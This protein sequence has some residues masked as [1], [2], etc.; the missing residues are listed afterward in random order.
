MVEL[1]S[2]KKATYVLASI[3]LCAA[4]YAGPFF[5]LRRSSALALRR[6][7]A[8]AFTFA[9]YPL[10]LLTADRQPFNKPGALAGNL[11]ATFLSMI[12]TDS[13]NHYL[14]FS[15]T[16][17]DICSTGCNDDVAARVHDMEPGTKMRLA[18]EGQLRWVATGPGGFIMRDRIDVNIVSTETIVNP[19]DY[20]ASDES[21]TPPK[22]S[23]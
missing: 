1:A 3:L 20:P 15:T 14:T 9:Y 7:A 11:E 10:R 16:A 18:W 5:A 21:I 17:G 22:L 13:D 2:V 12:T 23:K 19:V 6:P 4:V 8:Q